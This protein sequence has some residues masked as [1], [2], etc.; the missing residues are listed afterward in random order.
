[1]SQ[2][3]LIYE[4]FFKVSIEGFLFCIVIMTLFN[5]ITDFTYKTRITAE[6]LDFGEMQYFGLLSS[7]LACLNLLTNKFFGFQILKV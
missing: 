2:I 7:F 5:L 3:M 4:R 6:I 1:M